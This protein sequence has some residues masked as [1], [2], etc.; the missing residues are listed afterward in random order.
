MPA[1]W[2]QY[3]WGDLVTLEYGKGLTS[4]ENAAGHYPV[5]GTN[6]QIGWHTEPLYK[7]AGVII[8]R[9][10]AYRGF[11]ILNSLFLSLTLPFI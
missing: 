5:Y 11:I 9:K 2:T 6:G 1:D 3:R 7:K 4:Y 8:G 10:G